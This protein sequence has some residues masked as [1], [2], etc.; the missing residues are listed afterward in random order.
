M[1]SVYARGHD[2]MVVN[3]V[4]FLTGFRTG[5]KRNI[6]FDV[7]FLFYHNGRGVLRYCRAGD[8]YV[9]RMDRIAARL[10]ELQL[11]V[12]VDQ[13]P[14]EVLL[15]REVDVPVSDNFD[16]RRNI[17]DGVELEL[18]PAGEVLRTARQ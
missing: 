12:A 15:V 6:G 9:L 8:D 3:L 2:A 7:L 5:R 17:L 13:Y 10:D 1:S 11:A 18:L 14:G 16:V 4:D